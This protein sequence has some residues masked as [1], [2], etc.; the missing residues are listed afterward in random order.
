[1]SASSLSAASVVITGLFH[2]LTLKRSTVSVVWDNDP[3]KRMA[4][5]VPY[6]CSLDELQAEAEKRCG[7]CPRWQ[8][9]SRSN[10]RNEILAVDEL[11]LACGLSRISGALQ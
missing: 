8:Q 4:L 7:N 1:M 9:E 10:C 5:P 3:D 11:R 6:G 2:D